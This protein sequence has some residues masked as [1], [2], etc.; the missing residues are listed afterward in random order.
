MARITPLALALVAAFS[1]S[2]CST[3]P[4]PTPTDTSIPATE[5]TETFDGQLTV[6]GAVAHPFAVQRSGTVTLRLLAL[7]PSDATIGLS[8][9]TWNANA[10]VCALTPNL[11]NDSAGGGATVIGTA[12]VP[13][14]FCARV[15]DVGRLSGPTLYTLNVTHF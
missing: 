11:A 12:S 4:F 2:A 13:G 1:V 6:N 8:L 3:N 5:V 10:N 15:Y 14:S 7:D 9:G